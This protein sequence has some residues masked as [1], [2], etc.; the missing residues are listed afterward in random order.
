MKT[1]S[2]FHA[3]QAAEKAIKGFLVFKS[4]RV[5]KSHNL[6]DLIKLI[7]FVGICHRHMNDALKSQTNFWSP[8]SAQNF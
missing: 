6:G 7:L 4:V 1:L 8:P 3:Q 2:A 5:P